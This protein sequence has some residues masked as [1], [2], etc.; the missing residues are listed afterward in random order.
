[1]FPTKD[2]KLSKLPLTLA[3]DAYD[4]TQALRTGDVQVAGVDLNYLCLPVEETFHRMV[5]FREF[6]AAELSLSSYLL[7]LDSPD[8]P[9]VAIPVFPSRSFRHSGIYINTDAGIRRPEDLVG[10]VI[11]VPEYQVT[12]AVW[13]RGILADHYGVPVDSV[14]Y[15]TG[16]LHAPGREE[17]IA[18][19]LPESIDIEPIHPGRTLS[20]MLV[21]GEIDALHTPRTPRPFAEGRPEVARLFGDCREAEA[22]YFRSTGIFPIMHVLAIRR[23]VYEANRWIARSLFTAFEE[24]RRLAMADID[25]TAS[26]R[27]MVP[28]LASEIARTRDIMGEDYWRYGLDDNDPTLGQFLAYSHEQGLASRRWAPAELFAPEA[29]E[30][31]IV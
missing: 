25:E 27:Y 26:L 15:R 22:D 11:G 5:K 8:Q 24:S 1:V 12:A 28:W 31:V 2:G 30:P 20:E 13:I 21:S 16:G 23:D 14:R 18:L 3:C 7:T 9:F 17:K 4:R 29:S 6:D 19:S 10:R